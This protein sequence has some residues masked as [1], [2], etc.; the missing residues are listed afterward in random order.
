MSLIF[1]WHQPFI[2]IHKIHWIKKT[3]LVKTRKEIT[4][5]KLDQTGISM[6]M[7][8][9]LLQAATMHWPSARLL[10]P[11]II[12]GSSTISWRWTR[13]WSGSPSKSLLT[14]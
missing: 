13:S 4:I 2:G 11:T 7:M 8:Q 12:S 14:L 3:L 9:A 10:I 1:L 6:N 5:E